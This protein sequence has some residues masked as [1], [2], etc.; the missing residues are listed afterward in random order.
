MFP[1]LGAAGDILLFSK[2]AL[3]WPHRTAHGI[4]V[5]RPG[6]EPMSP[7]VEV[8]GPNHWTAGEFPEDAFYD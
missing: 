1:L 5:P 8:W 7:A 3:F 4:L 6:I 2:D